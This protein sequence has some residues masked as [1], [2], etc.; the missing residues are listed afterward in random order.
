MSAYARSHDPQSDSD[1]AWSIR[2][3]N[4][5]RAVRRELAR[6]WKLCQAGC[7]CACVSGGRGTRAEGWVGRWEGC[8]C[9]GGGF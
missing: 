7:V 5:K 1:G 3:G 9:V 2:V 6:A 8:V 4:G